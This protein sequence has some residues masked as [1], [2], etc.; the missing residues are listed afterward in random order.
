MNHC[1]FVLVSF[2]RQFIFF[3]HFFSDT[4]VTL[5]I[6][7]QCWS[8]SQWSQPEPL[9][10]GS[11]HWL[12]VL[13]SSPAKL[14]GLK[15]TS[16]FLAMS[17][18]FLHSWLLRSEEC[19]SSAGSEPSMEQLWWKRDNGYSNSLTWIVDWRVLVASWGTAERG[20]SVLL[21]NHLR[22]MY[23]E[24]QEFQTCSFMHWA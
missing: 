16:F 8:W 23:N 14:W 20:D 24:W 21:T 4:G 9:R 5:I 19:H 17:Q 7:S 12:K 6:Q 3:F 2:L 15:N 1:Y 10:T 11:R 22:L 13:A 18:Y